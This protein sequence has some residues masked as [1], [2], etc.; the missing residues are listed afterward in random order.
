MIRCFSFFFVMTLFTTT[1]NAQLL[2]V[3]SVRTTEDSAGWHGELEFDLSLN[4]YNERVLEFTNE[5]NLS[6]FS[7]KHAYMLLNNLNFVNIDGN[8][9]ISSGYI[10]LRSTFLRKGKWSPEV[11]TQ[12]QYNNNLGLNNRALGGAG[13]KYRFYRGEKW[14][15][16]VSTALMYEFEEWQ[17]ANQPSIENEFV[18]STSNV[19]LRGKLSNSATFLLVG[20][21]QAR[22]NQF[23]KARSILEWE[24]EMDITKRIA[25]SISFI[26]SYDAQPIIDIPNLTYA[27]SNGLVI[28]L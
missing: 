16:S 20:Y 23:L 24:I 19:S 12:Y 4:G 13:I 2:N 14:Q 22:P 3:E 15:A 8:S 25:L 28:E 17:L 27:L 7:K 11:F 26:M 5:S 10:H 6:Y 9:L 1:L 21:Y 18:K